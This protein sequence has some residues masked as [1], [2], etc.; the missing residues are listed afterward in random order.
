MSV[1]AV[2]FKSKKLRN[3]EHP[4]MLRYTFDRKVKYVSTGFVSK[5]VHWD[6]KKKR[7]KKKHPE[8]DI[9][10]GYLDFQLGR[11]KKQIVKFTEEGKVFTFEDF[12]VLVKGKQDKVDV[13]SFTEELIARKKSI[14]KIK[15][16]DSYKDTLYAIRRCAKSKKSL[17]FHDVNYRFLVRMEQKLR[18]EGAGTN[19]IGIYMRTFRAIFNAAIKEQLVERKLYPFND[20]KVS[21]LKEPTRKRAL[22]KEHVRQI[23][24]LALEEGSLRWHMRNYFLFSYYCRGIN[25][26]DMAELTWENISDGRLFY[27]R[28]KTKDTFN[29]KLLPKAL[30]ILDYYRTHS[31]SRYVFPIFNEGHKTPQQLE[32]RRKKVLKQYNDSLSEMGEE[33]GLGFRITSY[34][35]RHTYATVAKRGKVPISMISEAMGHSNEQVTQ[36]YLDSFENTELDD[37]HEG[38]L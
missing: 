20:Y 23:E 30:E 25:F 22:K 6:D 28:S 18:K 19:T 2:L 8:Y 33:I 4:I 9:I 36:A 11:V 13:Y 24:A 12:E 35:A 17:S 16:A 3:G 29:I 27:S 7:P 15:T 31:D 10:D 38:I 5:P 32:N 21:K 34:F 1:T 37:A 14:G 26:K